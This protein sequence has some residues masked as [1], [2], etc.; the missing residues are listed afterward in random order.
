M[1]NVLPS[2]PGNYVSSFKHCNLEGLEADRIKRACESQRAGIIVFDH[3]HH[4][5]YSYNK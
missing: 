3:F 5:P 2:L 1:A 4:K